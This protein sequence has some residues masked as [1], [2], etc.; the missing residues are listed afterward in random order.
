MNLEEQIAAKR[1]QVLWLS[2]DS[3]SPL[4]LQVEAV[5][6]R[7]AALKEKIRTQ[8][9]DQS[10]DKVDT[11]NNGVISREEWIAARTGGEANEGASSKGLLKQAL[12]GG[13]G[14]RAATSSYIGGP[15]VAAAQKVGVAAYDT[16]FSPPVCTDS[17]AGADTAWGSLRAGRRWLGNPVECRGWCRSLGPRDK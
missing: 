1:R 14:D 3:F 11:D 12:A 9:I 2:H 16:L 17:R 5:R 7:K 4:M 6:A 13:E 10:F 15:F 8:G